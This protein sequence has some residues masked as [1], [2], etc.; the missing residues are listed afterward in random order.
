MG[1]NELQLFADR[2]KSLRS[3]LNITQKDFADKVGITAAALSSYENNLK[4]PSIAVAKRISEAF[5][6]SIDWLCGLSDKKTYNDEIE[7]YSDVIRLFLKLEKKLK[8]YVSPVLYID[9]NARSLPS[10][11]FNNSKIQEFLI[12]WEKMKDLHDSSTIDDDVYNLWIEK[13]LGKYDSFPV[14]NMKC[15]DSIFEIPDEID[16]G[17]SSRNDDFLNE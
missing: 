10:I 5:N 14:T 8:I 9:L 12:E 13:T 17:L 2:L 11:S 1:D 6:V 15:N 16:D 7:T 3:E 4:N